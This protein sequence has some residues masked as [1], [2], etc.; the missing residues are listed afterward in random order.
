M[1][2][3]AFLALGL[4]F[5]A[6]CAVYVRGLDHL[7]HS[8]RQADAATDLTAVSSEPALAGRP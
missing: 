7:V 5:L 1:A 2:D 3:I 6:L 4:G 8:A